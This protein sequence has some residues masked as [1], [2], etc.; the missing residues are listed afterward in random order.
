MINWTQLPKRRLRV[1]LEDARESAP[2]TY[3]EKKKEEEEVEEKDKEKY[4]FQREEK[5]KRW[6]REGE[7]I[8]CLYKY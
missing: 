8:T 5:K 7:R 4:F 3:E 2:W 6:G 1:S